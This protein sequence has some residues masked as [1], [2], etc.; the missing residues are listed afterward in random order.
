[1][2]HVKPLLTYWL[3]K[4]MFVEFRSP[5]PSLHNIQHTTFYHNSRLRSSFI[6]I[7]VCQLLC[8]CICLVT[9][10]CSSYFT[11]A[12]LSYALLI[13]LHL[14][15]IWALLNLFQCQSMF[16][17]KPPG[18]ILFMGSYTQWMRSMFACD[19]SLSPYP[20]LGNCFSYNLNVLK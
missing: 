3:P 11:N 8:M 16:R 1:M 4:T 14:W 20:W 6:D 7:K 18:C 5:V 19:N 13:W 17:K 9:H 15:L 12:Y 10:V 2:L